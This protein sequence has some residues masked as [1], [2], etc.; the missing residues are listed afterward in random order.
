MHIGFLTDF[1]MANTTLI[2]SHG[3]ILS[4]FDFLT[5]QWRH[6]L[7]F[8]QGN[9][10]QSWGQTYFG[11]PTDEIESLMLNYIFPNSI[12][13][14]I[15]KYKGQFIRRLKYYTELNR[16]YFE[17]AHMFEGFKV[18]Q[19]ITHNDS[20]NYRLHGDSTTRTFFLVEDDQTKE[21]QIWISENGSRIIKLINRIKDKW[22]IL[23]I[24]NAPSEMLPIYSETTQTLT[25]YDIHNSKT[26]LYPHELQNFKL[27]E[28][29]A[30]DYDP[31]VYHFYFNSKL[32]FNQKGN[33]IVLNFA[34]KNPSKSKLELNFNKNIKDFYMMHPDTI[35]FLDKANVFRFAHLEMQV[36]FNIDK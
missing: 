28:M 3:K 5:N 7:P 15:I 8:E 17:K 14:C 25:I 36:K 6:M 31:S 35:Y 11:M 1:L 23:T 9:Q 12:Y 34:S 32:Y 30:Y 22:R 19:M 21:Q 24:T 26:C 10:N 13:D 33:L 29:A 2:I 18:I 16:T 27:H 20:K 4:I